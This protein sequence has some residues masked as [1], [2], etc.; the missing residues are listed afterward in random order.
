ALR[1]QGA[2]RL[3]LIT[4]NS[5]RQTLNRRV[6]EPH[7]NAPKNPVSLVFAIPDHPWVD[8]GDGAAVRIAMTVAAPGRLLTLTG[9]QQAPAG[10]EGR[11]VTLSVAEGRIFADLRIGADVAGAQPLR[12]NGGL[13]SQGVKLHGAGFIVT[14]DRARALGLGRVPGLDLHIRAYRNGRDLMATPRGV[15]VI[16]LFGLAEAEV[17]S[18]FPAVYQHV[19]DHVKPERD[20]NNRESYRQNWWIHGEPRKDLRPALAGLPRYIATVET[21]KHRIFQFLDA[22]TLADNMLIAIGLS[23]AAAL[24]VLSSRVHRTWALT[25]GGTLG[26]GPRYTKTKCLDPFPFPDLPPARR[27]RLRDLGEELDTHRKARQAEHPNL[28]L[29][30]IYNVLD[31]LR[32]GDTIEGRDRQVY[33]Q[34][35]CGLLHDIHTRID[36]AVAEAYGWPA[37]LPEA[38]ILHRLTALN[39]ARTAE[40]ARGHIRWLR[41]EY[42]NPAGT[43]AQTGGADQATMQIA[44]GDKTAKPPFPKALPE[45]IAAVRAALA[46][47]GTAGADQIARQFK[48]TGPATVQPLLESLAALGQARTLHNN[49]FAL[50]GGVAG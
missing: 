6:L 2:R 46:E 36:A 9:K 3:G 24:S 11:T 21:A 16:D 30:Q 32:A 40:E 22:D 29:T 37:D 5:L 13:T 19:R 47:L 49:R 27:A 7:L 33:E 14:P 44:T 12:A 41:P 28:T 39:R 4:T 23:D 26:G 10:A 42:Q 45:Q 34:G 48:G 18:R 38:D 8:A 31:K 1:A 50:A 25:A 20:Q 17:R 15:M 43:T 35:L